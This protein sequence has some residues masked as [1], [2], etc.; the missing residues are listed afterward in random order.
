[1]HVALP[2]GQGNI[3]MG[4][5]ALESM[6]HTLKMGNNFSLTINV[7]SKKE[8]DQIFQ[9]LSSGG[10]MTMP[11]QDAFWGDYFGMLTDK[12]GIQW[13]VAYNYNRR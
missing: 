10:E 4:T 11:I 2:L 1:M 6:G 7:D 12:Y 9:N 5:D 8:A 3:L 13:M